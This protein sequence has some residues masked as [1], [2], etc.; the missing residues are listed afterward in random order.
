MM[1]STRTRRRGSAWTTLWMAC[2]AAIA[3]SGCAEK[4]DEKGTQK[5]ATQP[6][7]TPATQAKPASKEPLVVWINGD[8]GYNGL[9]EVGK[10]FTAATGVEVK[11]EH[12]E[13]A[14]DKF[15]T[16]AAAG[17]G[18]DV[19]LW[20]HDRL[21]EWQAA[22][23]VAEVKP[24]AAVK[25]AIEQKGWDAFTIGGKTWGY[26]VAFEAVG[27]LYNKALVPEPPATWEEIPALHKK[28]QK[29]GKSAILWDYKNTYFTYGLLAAKGGYAFKR[30]DDGSY[31][32]N[33][34]GVNNDGA[35]AGLE[36]LVKMIDD[37]IMA[38]GAGYGEMEAGMAAGEIAMIINGPWGWANIEKA[39]I[40]YGVA[41]LPTLGGQPSSPF[42]G[43]LGAMVNQ[44][45]KN[46]EVAV[47]FIENYL[48]APE[49]LELIDN[50]KKIG[51]PAVKAFYAKL[52]GD[53][54]IAA[55]MENVKAGTLM[56]NNPEMGKFWDAMGPALENAT[57]GRQKPKEALDAAYKR[58]TGEAQPEG[59][60]KGEEEK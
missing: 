46:K 39:N 36:T 14:T 28:L 45:S 31:D 5:S 60:A 57:Q 47:E 38:K 10:K 1:S 32:A 41:P 19:F 6:K 50:D 11:V 24:G 29:D 58:I 54:K 44:A 4:K 49:N 56:P 21:G 17:K 40:D 22:G 42:V 53:A 12:P 7:T 33:D 25:S 3:V 30:L 26:P 51:V 43:V 59:E 13:S 8:K 2:I 18:P 52:S 55:T 20:A 27:L 34:I 48:L 9:A 15:Q 16:A 23:L 35:V 37:G